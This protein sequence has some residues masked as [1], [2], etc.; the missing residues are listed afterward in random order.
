MVCCTSARKFLA[1]TVQIRHSNTL[2]SEVEVWYFW[3]LLYACQ[4]QRG[5]VQIRH[6]QKTISLHFNLWVN[7]GPLVPDFHFVFLL[8]MF[9][10]RTPMQSGWVWWCWGQLQTNEQSMNHQ[11]R[12][13]A[14][15]STTQAC[16]SLESGDWNY[17]LSG[18]IIRLTHVNVWE[19]MGEPCSCMQFTKSRI[20][21]CESHE[22][23]HQ[24]LQVTCAAS[25]RAMKSKVCM[26]K[27]LSP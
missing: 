12:Q 18:I 16:F 15:S 11:K 7:K 4:G 26:M 3:H 14:E 20:F 27:S 23:P 8:H 13:A 22:N 10:R 6:S 25:E 21:Y 5:T 2:T 24:V 1:L 17:P 19:S 9:D